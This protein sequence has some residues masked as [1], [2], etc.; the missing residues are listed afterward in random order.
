M[1]GIRVQ[2]HTNNIEWIGPSKVYDYFGE[3]LMILTGDQ[4][5]FVCW[6]VVTEKVEQALVEF[7]GIRFYAHRHRDFEIL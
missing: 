1:T 4:G 3:P 7:H 6:D 5:E 2:K